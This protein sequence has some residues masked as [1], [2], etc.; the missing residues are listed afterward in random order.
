MKDRS[1]V[2][3]LG[4]I[5]NDIHVVGNRVLQI[6]LEAAGF[7]TVNIGT[8]AMPGD[9]I[10]AALEVDADAV[11]VGSLNGEAPHWCGGLRPGLAAVDKGDAWIYLGGNVVTGQWDPDRVRVHF[12][13]MGV[14]RVFY[15][16]TDFDVL[17]AQLES[18]IRNGRSR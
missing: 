9:F 17:V 2:V 4:V 8:N 6:C 18:D 5:G 13:A 16:A 12:E 11:L 14:D 1:P 10:D 7:R 15:G 3:V